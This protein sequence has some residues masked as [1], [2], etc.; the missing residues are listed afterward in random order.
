MFS[1]KTHDVYQEIQLQEVRPTYWTWDA[2]LYT[3][4]G[5]EKEY[6]AGNFEGSR[7]H[8]IDLIGE[9]LKQFENKYPLREK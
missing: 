9:K 3:R 7:K 1:L 4:N 8:A 2:R 6:I 5:H